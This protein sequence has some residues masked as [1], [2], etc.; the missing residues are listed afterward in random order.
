VLLLLLLLLRRRKRKEGSGRTEAGPVLV[1]GPW[2][3]YVGRKRVC[4][5]LREFLFL[6]FFGPAPVPVRWSNKFSSFMTTN[7]HRMNIYR[8]M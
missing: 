6:F 3:A 4:G 7:F 1:S 8:N 2:A 5:G